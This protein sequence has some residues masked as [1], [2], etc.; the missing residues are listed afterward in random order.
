MDTSQTDTASVRHSMVLRVLVVAG[1][2]FGFTVLALLVSQAA[3]ASEGS[4]PGTEPAA[5]DS[6]KVVTERVD[7]V[8]K[9]V[10]AVLTPVSESVHAVSAQTAQVV[11]PVTDVLEPVVAPL[12]R[13]VL[14][15]AEPV[16]SALRPVTKPVLPALDPVLRAAAPVT[17]PLVRAVGADRVPAVAGQPAGLRPRE[18]TTAVVAAVV[19]PPDRAVPAAGHGQLPVADAEPAGLRHGGRPEPAKSGVTADPMRGSG[20]GQLPSDS[21]GVSGSMSASPGGQRGGEFAVTAPGARE[22]GTGRAWRA[23]PS[24]RASLYWLVFYG[25]DH[26]S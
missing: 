10:E 14:R 9:P 21:T 17:E 12:T 6:L 15:A 8:L 26:P 3:D 11:Q 19:V 24:G 1:A 5:H 4:P 2:L 20:G 13:P 23:P 18:D 22:V 7:G 16:L 25:N